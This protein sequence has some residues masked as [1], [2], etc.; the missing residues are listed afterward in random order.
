MRGDSVFDKQN[1]F[2]KCVHKSC[3]SLFKKII[4]LDD[5]LYEFYEDS[6]ISWINDLPLVNSLVLNALKKSKA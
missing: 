5:K 2:E 6:E 3:G 4:V 1:D